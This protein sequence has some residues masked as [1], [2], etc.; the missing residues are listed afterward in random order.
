MMEKDVLQM[1][2]HKPACRVDIESLELLER[3]VKRAAEKNNNANDDVIPAGTWDRILKCVEQMKAFTADCPERGPSYFE[4]CNGYPHNAAQPATDGP[5]VEVRPIKES[6]LKIGGI[7]WIDGQGQCEYKRIDNYMGES[8]F[9]FYS[10]TY[11][12]KCYEKDL[13]RVY[14]EEVPSGYSWKGRPAQPTLAVPDIK[15]NWLPI[16]TLPDSTF[17]LL[18]QYDTHEVFFYNSCN[19]PQYECFWANQKFFDKEKNDG[20]WTHWMPVTFIHPAAKEG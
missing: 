9:E 18:E 20:V 11:S 15:G 17:E 3:I 12:A 5:E 14:P 19:G 13:R 16:E 10:I 7:F 4:L 8:T 2:D 6:D 1:T